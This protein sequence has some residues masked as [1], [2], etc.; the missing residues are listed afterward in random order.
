MNNT[1]TDYRRTLIGLSQ[2]LDKKHFFIVGLTRPGTAW[3][4][5]AINAHPDA[6]CK[7]EGHFTNALFPLLGKAFADYNKHMLDD[8]ARLKT[9]AAETVDIATNVEVLNWARKEAAL[10]LSDVETADATTLDQRK[11]EQQLNTQDKQA[12]LSTAIALGRDQSQLNGAAA[13]LGGWFSETMLIALAK[14][15]DSAQ[16]GKPAADRRVEESSNQTE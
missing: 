8:Q 13:P 15:D 16:L 4:Q 7:G 5:H 12:A 2:I 3:L 11:A 14:Y 1:T 6:L 10:S 9:P